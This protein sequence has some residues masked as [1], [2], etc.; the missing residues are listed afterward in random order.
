[1]ARIARLTGTIKKI[2][3][4][5]YG[6]IRSG[7]DDYFFHM[8]SLGAGIEFESLQPGQAVTFEAAD[9]KKG[10]RAESIELA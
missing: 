5:G 4:K 8:D 3:Q 9:G 1:M 10:P 7:N 6:F 2:T